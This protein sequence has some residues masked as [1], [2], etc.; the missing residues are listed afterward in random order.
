MLDDEADVELDG[1]ECPHAASRHVH[2]TARNN[3]PVN[4]NP[5]L[6]PRHIGNFSTASHGTCRHNPLRNR[7]AKY[8]SRY[9]HYQKL[10]SIPNTPDLGM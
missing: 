10:S 3:L 6:L 5:P 8:S 7:G 9:T 1:D 2:T 4:V